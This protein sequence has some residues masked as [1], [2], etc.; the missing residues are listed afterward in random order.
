MTRFL[1]SILLLIIL[2]FAILSCHCDEQEKITILY[3]VHAAVKSEAFY[4]CYLISLCSLAEANFVWKSL[5]VSK[6][7]FR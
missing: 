4:A 6:W 3:C 1:N 7:Q 2:D 5:R